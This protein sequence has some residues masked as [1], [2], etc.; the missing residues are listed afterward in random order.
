MVQPMILADAGYR[1]AG[2]GRSWDNPG[3][4]VDCGR[5]V[6]RVLVTLDITPEV[7]EEA[8]AA[9]Q[10]EI[11]VS[12]HPVIFD[13]LK[14]RPPEMYPLAGASGHFCHLY[15]HQSGCRRG[16]RERGAGGHLRDADWEVF[17][18]GCGRVGEP[19]TPS[20]CRSWPARHSRSLLRGAT[21]RRTARGAGQV[22]G[23]G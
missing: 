3:L 10:C 15:A 18:D 22:C 5:E 6:F 14:D 20:R 21:S 17:A 7:L 1:A 4:L 19:L 13:P 8:A 11:I 9:K 23:Y 16:R 12:H 2:T